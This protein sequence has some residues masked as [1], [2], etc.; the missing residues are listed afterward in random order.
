VPERRIDPSHAA[1]SD[2][3]QAL[4]F[5]TS[6]ATFKNAAN[7]C[8]NAAGNIFNGGRERDDLSNGKKKN[9]YKLVTRSEERFERGWRAAKGPTAWH[10]TVSTVPPVITKA[11]IYSA[12]VCTV[13]GI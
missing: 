11:N 1:T 10:R 7:A 3:V 5:R 6:D 8:G 4:N 9:L 12:V 2:I 13:V